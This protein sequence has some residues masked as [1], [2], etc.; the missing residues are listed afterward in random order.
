MRLTPTIRKI[1]SI[2][3]LVILVTVYA[4]V[5]VTIAAAVLSN[6]PWYAQAMFFM[7]TGVLWIIPAMIIIKWAAQE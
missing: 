1:M 7:T 3:F 5:A 4:L 6:A 2:F